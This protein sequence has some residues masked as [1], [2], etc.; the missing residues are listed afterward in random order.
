MNRWKMEW[1]N[2]SL[3]VIGSIIFGL[4]TNLIVVPMG[5]YTGGILG[6]A[7]IIR[8]ILIE[9]LHIPIPAQLDIAGILN[10]LLNIPLFLMAYRE[11]S[12]R[13]LVKTMLSLVVQTMTLTMIFIPTTPYFNDPWM[14]CLIGGV[15]CG[16]GIGLVLR[17]GGSGGGADIIG[18]WLTQR[19]PGFSVGK[20][21]TSMN[22]VVYGLCAILFNPMIAI[23][24]IIYSVI[25]STSMDRIHYQN[26]N[27]TAMI[28]T[29]VAGIDTLVNE[30]M[31]RGVTKW[32]GLGSY[33]N[34]KT[35]ILV[36]VISKY[37]VNYLKKLIHSLDPKAFVIFY[38][39]MS[40]SGNFEKRL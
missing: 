14:A 24:S 36:T 26:I 10:F 31:T 21:F 19:I 12:K 6:V 22:I 29:K 37:E 16:V 33:T 18:V 35:H 5:Y 8:T 39:G 13:F 23:Y 20:M 40:V 4:G 28:F 27:M 11:I 38:E 9:Y 30:K 2:I 32:E 15:V 25:M 1:K 7:Q 3:V 17:G 34:E